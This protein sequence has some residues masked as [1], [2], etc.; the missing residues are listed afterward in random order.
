MRTQICIFV[1]QLLDRLLFWNTPKGPRRAV[2]LGRRGGQ[3]RAK[4]LTSKEQKAIATKASKAAAKAR[5][6]KATEQKKTT[7]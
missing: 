7:P 6:K 5:A 1:Y 4:A 3:A 2:E